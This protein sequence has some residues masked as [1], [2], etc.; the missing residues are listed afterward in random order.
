LNKSLLSDQWVTEDI[1][2]EIKKFL[3][4]NKMKTQL[5]RTLGNSKGSAKSNLIAMSFFIKK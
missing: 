4:S 1:K 5:D 3:Y 2:E